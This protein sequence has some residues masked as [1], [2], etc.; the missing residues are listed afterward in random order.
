MTSKENQESAYATA[1]LRSLHFSG[2]Q[3]LRYFTVDVNNNVRC[4]VKPVDHLLKNG[5]GTTTL[6]S[7]VSVAEVCFAG[8]P[9]YADHMIDGTGMNARNVLKTQPDLSSFRILPYAPKSALVMCN[10]LD[11]YSDEPSPLCTRGLLS[12][13]VKEAAEK[14]NIAFVSS[15]TTWHEPRDVISLKEINHSSHI[16][17]S[18]PCSR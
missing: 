15:I 17:S 13:V 2:V 8:L 7:Q 4:K 10:L 18:R 14:H 5:N 16:F 9:H 3:F 6:D 12:K 1:L 11:Q